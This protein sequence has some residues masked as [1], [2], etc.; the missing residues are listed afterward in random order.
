MNNVNW[1]KVHDKLI[2]NSTSILIS[3]MCK[4]DDILPNDMLNVLIDKEIIKLEYDH[5][6]IADNDYLDY[7]EF[8]SVVKLIFK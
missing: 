6:V 2:K 7:D 3:R 4:L 1:D 5:P 8:I